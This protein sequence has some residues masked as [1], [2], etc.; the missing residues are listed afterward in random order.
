MRLYAVVALMLL[1]LA[2]GLGGG[3]QV[4]GWKAAKDE[5]ALVESVHAAAERVRAAGEAAVKEADRE[6]SRR[7]RAA[8]AAAAADRSERD[9]VLIAAARIGDSLRAASPGSADAGRLSSCAAAL[10][11]GASLLAEGADLA[12]KLDASAAAGR[13]FAAGLGAS[14]VSGKVA[15]P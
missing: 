13:A 8:E 5:A 2:A 10:A 11:E 14:A 15:T 3:W 6:G 1:A 9:G 7:I 12:R 4:R